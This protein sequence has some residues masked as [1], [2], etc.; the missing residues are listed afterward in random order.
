MRLFY[1]V[2]SADLETAADLSFQV[3][4]SVV[5]TPLLLMVMTVRCLGNNDIG[6]HVTNGVTCNGGSQIDDCIDV[7][8]TCFSTLA[9]S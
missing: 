2:E 3:D 1:N 9:A 6:R 7:A 5:H 4:E 8:Y